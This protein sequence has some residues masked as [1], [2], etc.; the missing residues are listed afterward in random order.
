MMHGL[1]ERGGDVAGGEEYVYQSCTPSSSDNGAMSGSFRFVTGTVQD[2]TGSEI[3]AVVS[4][5]CCSAAV[6]GHSSFKQQVLMSVG[7]VS[8]TFL[9]QLLL[10]LCLPHWLSSV[11]CDTR[12]LVPC[13]CWPHC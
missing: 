3:Q 6:T 13:T 7:S 2:N 11:G 8:T 4:C 10:P 12:M 9:V 5:C 1:A